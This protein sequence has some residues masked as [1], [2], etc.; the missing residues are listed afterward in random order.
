NLAITYTRGKNIEGKD[1]LPIANKVNELINVP[2][3]PNL[4]DRDKKDYWLANPENLKA[5]QA[6]L[7]DQD[8]EDEKGNKITDEGT[9]YAKAV[10]K[11]TP[12]EI[13]FDD[14]TLQAVTIFKRMNAASQMNTVFIKNEGV[15]EGEIATIGEHTA[16]ISGVSTGTDWTRDYSQS[17]AL[18]SLL[19]TV[20]TEK[21]GLPAE[22]VDEY[23]K[24][25]YARND[26]VGTSYLEKQ[27]EDVL[28]GK[29]AKSEVVLDNNGKIV[30]QTPISKGEKGSN[31]KLT[32]DSN[33]QNK[34][35]EILQRNYSQ[36]VKTIGPYSENAYVVAMNP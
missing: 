11:V 26:R 5:A 19:G 17:G 23:L 34:V 16:E 15:T 8:K 13:A 36:I 7:T 18:R 20:S 27:Y 24:K 2:V 30:S 22:E 29:K 10:E 12:E 9:L 3:D 4:T 1:I 6:R 21:Q 31:L 25:G 33:F 28:Q 14:R 35:D 32:I